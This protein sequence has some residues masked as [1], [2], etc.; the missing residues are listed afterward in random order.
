MAKTRRPRKPAVKQ[1][2]VAEPEVEKVEKPKETFTVMLK[3]AV[4]YQFE[5]MLFRRG[6][7]KDVP[8]KYLKKFQTNGYFAVTV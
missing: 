4:T 5:G 1:P 2:S 8:M 3:E 7:S 6:V